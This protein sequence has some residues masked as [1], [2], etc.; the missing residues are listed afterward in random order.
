MNGITP[1]VGG[2]K[3][4][5]GEIVKRFPMNYKRYI[6]VFGGGGWVLFYK[7]RGKDFE[8]FND[9][10][11]LL[12]NLYRCVRE[13]PDELI[14]KLRYVLN[15]REDF[16]YVKKL[17]KR[18]INAPPVQ[19]AAWYYQ[20]LRQ[21]YGATLESYNAQPNDMWR[22][23]PLIQKASRRLAKVIIE[24][25]DFE[26]LIKHYDHP[27]SFFYCDPPYH[28]TEGYYKDIGEDGFTEKDHIRLR[29]TLLSIDGKF[30]LSYNDDN[31]VR[32]LY[33][34]PGIQ[35]DSVTRTN[36][37]TGKEF[38]EVIIANYDMHESQLS[39]F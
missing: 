23:F 30:L 35:I 32:E 15:S 27:T 39:L 28:D 21:S 7:R 14:E 25:Q 11:G 22:N 3:Q 16:E 12:V 9:I 26:T 20:I 8:V 19:R 17:L 31:F 34:F 37:F 29:D 1:W 38:K 24:N 6:E 18:E 2:K 33:D 4:L 36:G 10:N 13:N 5:R